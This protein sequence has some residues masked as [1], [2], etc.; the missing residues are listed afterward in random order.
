MKFIIQLIRK[1]VKHMDMW[2]DLAEMIRVARINRSISQEYLAELLDVSPTHIRH[3]E[4]G[5]RKPSLELLF[6]AAKILDLS[7]DAVIFG[8]K[9]KTPV[10]HTEGLTDEE[11]GALA[12][13]ADMLRKNR[14]IA[15]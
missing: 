13:L 7:V 1:M 4:S 15:L 2:K 5:H 11:I 14:G 12:R 9:E 10:I 3:I 6:E 8:A